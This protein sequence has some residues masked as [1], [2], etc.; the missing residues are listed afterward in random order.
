MRTFIVGALFGLAGCIPSVWQTTPPQLIAAVVNADA[1]ELALEFD[2]PV[3]GAVVGGDVGPAAPR[4]QGQRVTAGLAPGLKA[5]GRYVWSAEVKDSAGNQ[6]SVAGR[7]YGPNDHPASLRLNEVR[8]AGSGDHTDF[9]ELKVAAAGS[10]GGWTLD[11]YTGPD[12]RQRLVFPDV[13]V[14]EGEL[15]VV[16]YREGVSD[17][18]GAREFRVPQPKGLSATKGLLA[19]RPSPAEGP[20]DA[21][22]YSK[23][24]GEAAA[25]AA[26]AGWTGRDELNPENCTATRTWNRTAA[27]SWVL[28]ANGGASPGQ[29]NSTTVWSGPTPKKTAKP[30]ARRTHPRS[31][32][33]WRYDRVPTA[34]PAPA[35][36]PDVRR[37][38]TGEPKAVQ[39]EIVRWSSPRTSPR[40]RADRR[41]RPRLR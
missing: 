31:V 5:G 38:S 3:A 33:G 8:V 6:T 41:P 11:A 22:L 13:G 36:R 9:V 14:T 34:R 25:L 29:P 4:V 19:L 2:K 7:F 18:R 28:S 23:V 21:L 27:G 16:R 17:T 10:L 1:N 39:I 12:A 26:T 32:R 15:V 35:A 40:V 37:R 30:K 24:A 20:L